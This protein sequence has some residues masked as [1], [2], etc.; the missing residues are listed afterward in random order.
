MCYNLTMVTQKVKDNKTDNK[1]KEVLSKL[2]ETS[3]KN[4]GNIDVMTLSD[5]PF[6]MPRL[7]TGI[8]EIDLAIGG[9]LPEGKIVEIFGLESSGKTTCATVM[10]GAAQRAGKIA[11][12]V[13]VEHAFNPEWAAI[14]GVDVDNL[15]FVQPSYGEEALEVINRM[16]EEGVDFIVLDSVAALVPK[17]ELDGEMTDQQMG[18]QARMMGKFMRQVIPKMKDGQ[19][20]ICINQTREKVGIMFGNPETTPGG[21]ALKF[22][23]SIRLRVG[24]SANSKKDGRD[25]KVTVPKN[26]TAPPFKTAEFKILSTTGHD[27]VG[28]AANIGLIEKG[29]AWYTLPFE[30]NG[31]KVRLQGAEKVYNWL[32]EN[33]KHGELRTML[34]DAIDK[35]MQ[36][37]DVEEILEDPAKVEAD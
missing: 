35:M 15:L 14:N 11:A 36:P 28:S 22:A 13:D 25:V 32:D 2:R 1:V 8:P 30:E 18:L 34:N 17:V 10:L 37:T 23:A 5:K 9:G 4:I 26:K 16:F 24:G 6:K 21:K 29:G 3:G 27:Y 31:E 33:K 12:M 7:S 19:I 20:L